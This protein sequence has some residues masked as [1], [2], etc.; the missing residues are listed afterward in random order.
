MQPTLIL[1]RS[2]FE[3]YGNTTPQTTAGK[4]VVIIYGFLGCSGGILFFNLFLERIITFLAFVLRTVHLRRLK[5]RMEDGG[6]GARRASRISRIS[7]ASLPDDL[8]EDDSSLDHWKP[9]V[10]WVMLY[11]AVAS[12][13]LAL[14]AASVY[15]P[16][17]DWSFFESIYFCF[18]SF[19]TI[20]FGD[21]VST[22]VSLIPNPRQLL[23]VS[24]TTE[25]TDKF[26]PS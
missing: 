9:S 18:V 3:G 8:D 15:A 5:K 17:E 10:Y 14:C 11:L 19:A 1:A 22:Q 6:L 13:T 7:R 21:Y 25:V 26:C 20:G 24:S 16:F 4:A 23:S 2:L 12:V